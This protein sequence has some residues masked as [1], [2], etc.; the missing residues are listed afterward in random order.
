M[1]EK[2]LNLSIDRLS[3]QFYRKLDTKLKA[4]LQVEQERNLVLEKTASSSKTAI[5]NLQ[6]EQNELGAQVQ[7]LNSKLQSAQADINGL[8]IH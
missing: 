7:D 1:D 6:T 3:V 4:I 5:L 8:Q 2:D